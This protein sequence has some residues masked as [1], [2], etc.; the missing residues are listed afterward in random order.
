MDKA[1]L[2][3]ILQKITGVNPKTG[4]SRRCKNVKHPTV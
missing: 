1:L 3:V 2:S 4:G